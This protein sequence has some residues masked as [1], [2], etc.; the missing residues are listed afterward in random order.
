MVI[1]L[2][3]ARWSLSRVSKFGYVRAHATKAEMKLEV[4]LIKFH[5]CRTKKGSR[6]YGVQ[7]SSSLFF[8][9]LQFVVAET[10]RIED[11]FRITKMQNR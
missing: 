4:G 8:F 2:Q 10:D 3:A 6:D 11:A 9:P 1:C 5:S 7:A